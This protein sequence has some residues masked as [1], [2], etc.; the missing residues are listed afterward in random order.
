MKKLPG[1]RM[2]SGHFLII[3]LKENCYIKCN[4]LEIFVIYLIVLFD[5][6]K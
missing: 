6:S 4:Y 5:F 3:L 2:V 1:N